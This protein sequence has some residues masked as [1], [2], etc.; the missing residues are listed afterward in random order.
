MAQHKDLQKAIR[1]MA[2]GSKSGFHTFYLGTVQ[3]IY[4][5]ALLLCGGHSDACRFMV[6]FYQYLYLHLPGYRPSQD[7]EKWISRLIME[8]FSQLSIGRDA[9]PPTVRDRMSA[10]NTPLEAAERERVW[11]LLEERMH[12][13]EETQKKRGMSRVLFVT[14]LLLL[15]LLVLHYRKPFLE[16]LQNAVTEEKNG[17][18]DAGGND[19]DGENQA[20]A[21]NGLPDNLGAGETPDDGASL[22]FNSVQNDDGLRTPD[23]VT[24]EIE[25]PKVETPQT[26]TPNPTT[27]SVQEPTVDTPSVNEPT[28][29]P[30]SAGQDDSLTDSGQNLTDLDDYEL[31]LYYGDSLTQ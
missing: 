25:A 17:G 24:Q 9:K 16:M 30:P 7:L 23:T 12:F 22:D 29:N 26:N 8:R 1:Q 27:P 19:A 5:S 20:P 14:V 4:S 31:N 6:D 21:E 28:V 10:G 3:F 15:V 2:D 18:Q 13:P 11:R